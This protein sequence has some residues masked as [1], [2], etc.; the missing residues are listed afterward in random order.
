MGAAGAPPLGLVVRLW[1][2][3]MVVAAVTA[4]LVAE[5]AAGH[6]RDRQA[7]LRGDRMLHVARDLQGALEGVVGLGLMLEQAPRVQDMLERAQAGADALSIEVFDPK[8]RILFGT[9]RSF[10]GDLVAERW[11]AAAER[12]SGVWTV[13]DP[14]ALV[15]GVPVTDTLG[16]VVGTIAVRHAKV[17]RPSALALLAPEPEE[18][19]LIGGGVLL[20]A[21]VAFLTLSR[22]LAGLGSGLAA[23]RKA[24]AHPEDAA[25]GALA[26]AA[27]SAARAV[28]AAAQAQDRAL[29][30]ARRIDADAA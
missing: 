21:G 4:G 28:H 26:Q 12:A 27:A 9:D 25:G 18:R 23:A 29:A 16:A 5:V 22:L 19:L 6:L 11:M 14:D 30:E 7:A 17:P 8:G 10:L 15:V 24:L 1:L 2:V 20:F 13:E 3:L